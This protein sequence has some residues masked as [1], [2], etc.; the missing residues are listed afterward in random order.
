MGLN[1]LGPKWRRRL[2]TITGLPVVHGSSAGY[3]VVFTTADHRHG[4]FDM[5]PW[6]YSQDRL[7]RPLWGLYSDAETQHF[8]S[9]RRLFDAPLP[10]PAVGTR[11][12]VL[13]RVDTPHRDNAGWLGYTS[14]WI[15]AS[16]TVVAT[17]TTHPETGEAFRGCGISTRDGYV[18][19]RLC[20]TP[21]T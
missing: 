4:W 5:R 6:K 11:A 17:W 21:H 7:V 10:A 12:T 19:G 2:R 1:P 20:P 9:C 14:R 3:S 16:G 18:V 8:T 13:H 15:E